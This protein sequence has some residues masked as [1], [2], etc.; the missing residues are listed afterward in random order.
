M[1]CILSESFREHSTEMVMRWLDRLGA[2]SCR[3]NAD[4]V[5]QSRNG[6][7]L[8]VHDGVTDFE[9]ECNGRRQRASEVGAVWFRRWSSTDVFDFSPADVFG[10][11]QWRIFNTVAYTEHLQRELRVVNQA[12]FAAFR[13]AAWLNHP[14]HS[15]VN[16]LL[17]LAEAQRCGL[18]T[19]ATL[20]SSDPQHIL[21]FASRYEEVI[22]KCSSDM[23]VFR[24]G[25]NVIAP[26]TCVLDRARLAREWKGGFPMLVQERLNRVYELRI[27]YLD[28][29][30]ST[31]AYVHGPGSDHI[32]DGRL[33]T[34]RVTRFSLP[35]HIVEALRCLMGRLELDIACIDMVRTREDRWVFLEVNPNGQYFMD[36]MVCNEGLEKKIA[37]T[38]IRRVDESGRAIRAA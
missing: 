13:N 15:A 20:V 3:L 32:A 9:W 29:E 34:A 10:D 16:K 6:A 17:V 18:D 8:S 11:A 26:A 25:E 7:V 5:E 4:D 24:I 31:F 23:R 1:I 22:T 19:P 38:L 28:G 35:D 12:V 21:D 2:P 37:E 30:C 33:G 14:R 27:F 36:G